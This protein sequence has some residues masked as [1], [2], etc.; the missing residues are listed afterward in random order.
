MAISETT[1]GCKGPLSALAFITAQ[2]FKKTALTFKKTALT[3]IKAAQ[4]VLKAA[5]ALLKVAQAVPTRSSC[6]IRPSCFTQLK[7]SLKIS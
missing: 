2:A 4:A 1:T 3:F 5:Q 6:F 7:L